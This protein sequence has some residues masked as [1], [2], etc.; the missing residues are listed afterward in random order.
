MRSAY[1]KKVFVLSTN[2]WECPFMA[3]VLRDED[4]RS[5]I[6]ENVNN[7]S[8]VEKMNDVDGFSFV[9]SDDELKI[10]TD[11]LRE[12]RLE[13]HKDIILDGEL[14]LDD[15]LETEDVLKKFEGYGQ[16]DPQYLCKFFAA[17]RMQ[18]KSFKGLD[19]ITFEKALQKRL[20]YQKAFDDYVR[21]GGDVETLRLMLA[22]E[23]KER[24]ERDL[25]TSEV[26]DL[27]LKAQEIHSPYDDMFK[28]NEETIKLKKQY[29]KMLEDPNVSK[30]ELDA[31]QAKIDERDAA[32]REECKKYDPEML[33]RVA[34][35]RMENINIKNGVTA[36]KNGVKIVKTTDD[37]RAAKDILA[38]GNKMI[39]E[40]DLDKSAN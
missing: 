10:I 6:I 33:K 13:E 28:F 15:N 32:L 1:P 22:K 5:I 34:E 20:A 24:Q 14:L 40:R 8:I 11:V 19:G 39:K 37:Y 25:D 9:Y 36:D 16:Y 4:T 30:A 7:G 35:A 21:Q 2:D 31:L 12:Q 17:G 29:D 38:I 18:T 3:E 27:C 23:Q 26:D